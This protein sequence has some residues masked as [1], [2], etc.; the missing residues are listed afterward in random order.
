MAE[1]LGANQ[2]L[3]STNGSTTS[4]HAAMSAVVGPGEK[5]AVARNAHKS[6][7][8]GLIHTGAVPIWLEADYDEELELAHDITLDTLRRA[9][10]EHPDCRAVMIAT[11]T[12]YGVCSDVPAIAELVHAHDLPLVCD[13]AWALAYKFHPELPPFALDVGADIAIGS[14]HKTLSG[15]GQTSVISVKGSRI[16][17]DRLSLAL[18]TYE[19]T[20]GS[21]LLLASIDAAR[22]QMVQEGEA[23]I[24]NALR[25]ARRLRAG[26]RELGLGTMEPDDILHRDGAWHFNEMHVTV[27]VQELGVTGYKAGDWLRGHH[28]IAVELA[29]H[30]RVMFAI[31]HADTDDSIDDALAALADLRD[32]FAGMSLTRA[33]R[34][35]PGP[36]ELRTEQVMVPREAFYAQTETVPIEEAPGRVAAEF[37]TPYPP[38]IPLFVPGDRI[39][40]PIVEYLKTGAA[41]GIYAEGCADQTLGSLRVVS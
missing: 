30:R 9:L 4:V 14:V 21:S 20:S 24:G 3:F 27:D 2:A 40:E 1:A 36:K 22:R 28:A 16:D 26:A 11:P 12:Y 29:D 8:T 7:I 37:V 39:T 25:L 34:P 18:E 31:T 33:P 5:I 13:D 15:L 10:A 19:T 23:L 38:G 32:S 17:T 6:V 35:M 41:E